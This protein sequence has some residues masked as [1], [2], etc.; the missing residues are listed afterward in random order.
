MRPVHPDNQSV[1]AKRFVTIDEAF[2][3]F[4]Q[5]P[6]NRFAVTGIFQQELT[7]LP[8]RPT[9]HADDHNDCAAIQ[10]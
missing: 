5:S 1:F 3:F 9:A 7:V 8:D 4:N 2:L 6:G 10:M